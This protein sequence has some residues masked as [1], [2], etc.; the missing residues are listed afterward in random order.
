MKN[1]SFASLIHRHG[2]R[3]PIRHMLAGLDQF[4]EKETAFWESRMIN[5]D[6]LSA[7]GNKLPVKED[8]PGEAEKSAQFPFGSLTN[9]G[10]D[11][12]KAMGSDIQ[13]QIG[14]K[15]LNEMDP[16]RFF[17][18]STNYHRTQQS[19]Q[20]ML[21]GLLEGNE[22]LNPYIH[23]VSGKRD[24]A[25]AWESRSDYQTALQEAVR[26]P[27]FLKQDELMH[28]IK[29]EVLE[30]FP[31]F[32]EDENLMGTL[33]TPLWSIFAHD[34]LFT[35]DIHRPIYEFGHHVTSIDKHI[36]CLRKHK[37]AIGA[38]LM[39]TFEQIYSFDH[40]LLKS[41]DNLLKEIGTAMKQKIENFSMNCDDEITNASI[42]AQMSIYSAHD[43][44]VFPVLCL[45]D[46]FDWERDTW[47]P[48]A[49]SVLFQFG[50][51]DIFAG[52]NNKKITEYV[53]QISYNG[54]L[55][56]LPFAEDKEYCSFSKFVEFLKGKGVDI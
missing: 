54:K 49:S 8:I 45:F 19:A 53:V 14:S 9:I 38:H 22:L 50:E 29:K 40:V 31:V 23:S 15:F 36:E 26:S 46:L 51:R 27:L 52:N 28:E 16:S 17:V 10:F 6:Q 56:R 20:G 55:M 18:R 2:D 47:P 21:C 37:D 44:T 13:R 5:K 33:E 39:W 7:L 1:L 24:V 3:S 32:Y 34:Y 25:N 12:C 11:Q 42:N 48:F 30:C 41:C 35:R 43:V 4:H